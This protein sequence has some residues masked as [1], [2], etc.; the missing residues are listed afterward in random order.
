MLDIWICYGDSELLGF[1]FR[2]LISPLRILT[3]YTTSVFPRGHGR[4]K[5]TV[6]GQP[7]K[8][9]NLFLLKSV[10]EVLTTFAF[11]LLERL[12]CVLKYK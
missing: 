4:S 8:K 12:Q 11:L 7:A 2:Y 9:K 6:K 5:F 1:F 10:L 3:D